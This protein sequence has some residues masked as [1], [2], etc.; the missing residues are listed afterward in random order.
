MSIDTYLAQLDSSSEGYFTLLRT[1]LSDLFGAVSTISEHMR[2]GD[3]PHK[4]TKEQVGLGKV[5]NFPLATVGEAKVRDYGFAYMTPYL[6]HVAITDRLAEVD[7]T[8]VGLGSVQNYPIANESHA[9]AGSS[10]GHYM[11]PLRTQQNFEENTK[12]I[13]GNKGDLLFV[14]KDNEALALEADL[15]LK[16]NPALVEGA[17]E[18]AQVMGYIES[19]EMV[20]GDWKRISHDDSGV[21]P[22]NDTELSGWAYDADTD[23][24]SSTIDSATLIGFI[25][26]DRHEDY[27]FDVTISASGSDDDWI[28][29]CFGFVEEDG[30]EHTL[31]A[32][33]TPGGVQGHAM[34]GV[35][36]YAKLFDVW[37]NV[38][39]PATRRDL[40]STN[41]GLKWGDG[42]VDDSRTPASDLGGGGWGA[43]PAGC[44]LRV[45]RFGDVFTLKTSDLGESTLKESA[46]VVIDINDYPE[47]EKFRGPIQ[48]GYVCFS[49]PNATWEVH[50]RPVE[51]GTVVDA[52]T[53]ETWEWDGEQF[54]QADEQTARD[55]MLPNRLYYTEMTGKLFYNEPFKGLMRISG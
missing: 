44:R 43:Y 26:P 33:R 13:K 1:C 47:L 4:V 12:H 28:G 52:N 20:F 27:I 54:V 34:D 22:A 29:V 6:T 31:V 53:L 51:L 55:R 9:R 11:T 36:H 10:N 41:G 49:Q 18:M 45:E 23:S 50:R 2:N 8:F 35:T 32:M 37:Y 15:L 17:T 46:T 5:L 19:F 25:S 7:K 39:D 30:K 3:N 24:V 38:F 21:Y 14:S 48:F 40:G 16:R 42:V